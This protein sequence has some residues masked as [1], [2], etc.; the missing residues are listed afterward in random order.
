[1]EL[2]ASQSDEGGAVP[3]AIVRTREELEAA[4]ERLLSRVGMDK[5]TLYD[6]GRNFQL[7]PDESEIYETLRA[8]DYLLG[9]DE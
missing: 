8:I 6:L 3:T 1:M 4:R 2:V 7:R 5:D 9:D